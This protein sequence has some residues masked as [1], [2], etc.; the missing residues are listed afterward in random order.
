[1]IRG[2]GRLQKRTDTRAQFFTPGEDCVRD[3]RHLMLQEDGRPSTPF[4]AVAYD[5]L[6]SIPREMMRRLIE[7]AGYPDADDIARMEG[8]GGV[9]C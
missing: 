2:A 7:R 4:S 8:E 5:E 6:S 1:M 9:P 3:G